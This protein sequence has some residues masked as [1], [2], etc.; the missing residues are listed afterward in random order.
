MS[1]ID[2]VFILVEQR[3]REG[4]LTSQ[5]SARYPQESTLTGFYPDGQIHFRFFLDHGRLHGPGRI[6]SPEGKL[7][8]QDFFLHGILHGRQHLWYDN[9][10]PKSEID[11]VNGAYHG[12]RREWYPNGLMK[13]ECF[14][15][16]NLPDGLSTEWHENGLL[17]EQ[18]SF[19]DGQRHGME[20][21]YD[22]TGGLISQ[23]LYIRGVHFNGRVERLLTTGRLKVKQILRIRNTAVRRICLEEFGYERFYR[24]IPHQ[25]LD[26]DGNSELVKISW[27][28]DEEPVHLVKVKCPST[29]VF[30]LLRVPPSMTSV[31]QAVAWTFGV[32]EDQY[33]PDE[34]S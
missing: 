26:T 24:Q 15:Q 34:E 25:I 19:L 14:Y 9:G 12:R 21:E 4:F 5:S 27:H 17:K 2:E 28:K 30:Y 11:Y 23:K 6:W 33:S 7:I 3:H 8:R 16:M 18:M 22:E 13:S 31:R 29:G 10:H 1:R 20:K 32:A